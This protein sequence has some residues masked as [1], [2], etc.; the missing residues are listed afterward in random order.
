MFKQ[1]YE[2]TANIGKRV[3][4]DNERRLAI[5]VGDKNAKIIR[6][7]KDMNLEDF[8]TFVKRKGNIND[9]VAE[10]DS[11]LL[12]LLQMQ[13]ITKEEFADMFGRSTPSQISKKLRQIVALRAEAS[14]Q[15]AEQ[16]Q[17]QIQQQQQQEMLMQQ[18]MINQNNE[19]RNA[20]RDAG[21]LKEMMKLESKQSGNTTIQQ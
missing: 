5:A 12:G 19:Q 13:I 20:D 3:Y 17:L 8:R 18:N 15:A 11:L 21:L 6:I 7:T 2:S 14:R 16:Q 4:S 1:V 10:G 9:Q